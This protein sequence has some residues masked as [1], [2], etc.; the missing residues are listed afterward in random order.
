MSD[1]QVT[2]LPAFFAACP[3][4]LETL[5]GEE[6]TAL[7]AQVEKTTV[8]GVH[9][10]GELAV[11]Y[12]ACLWSRLANRIILCLI[13]EEGVESPEQL[14]DAAARVA[15]A[16]HLVPGRSLAVD[17]H[18][19]SAT[20][21]HTRFGAQTVK[22]GVVTAMAR[23]G[24]ERPTVEP[25]D[26]DL[27][28]YAHLHRGRLTLGIDFSGESLH[29]RGYR[30]ELGHAPLKE[31]LAAALLMRA[32]WPAR[33]KAGEALVDPLCGSG[34]L[35]IEAALMA[36][37]IAPNLNRA[38]FGLEAWA[39][40]DRELWRELRREAEARASLG[41]KRCKAR[42]FGSDQSPQ[43][44]AAA[45]ANAMRAGIPA[46][47]HFQ[48]ASV[49][50]LK[51][52]ESLSPEA[53]GLVITNPPYGER[54]GELP[55]LVT[56]YRQLGERLREAFPGWNLALFTGNPDLGHR[57]GMRAHKHYAFRNG[58]LEARLLLIAIPE[59]SGEAGSDARPE[60]PARSENAQM[61]ANRLLKNRKRLKKWLK[62]SGESCYRLYDADMPE[63]ALAIDVYGD[64]VHVQEYAPPKSVDAAQAQKRL[65]DA[66]GVIPE[67]LEVSPSR[68]V[69]KRRERQ[70]GRAQYQKQGSHGE[71]FE[72]RE[73][74]ARLWVNLRDYLDTGLFLDH[75]PVRRRLAE[76]AAGKRFLNLFCYTATATVQAALGTEKAGGASDTISVDLSNTYLSWA[77][78][79]FALNG[80]DPAHHRVV[81]DD[82]LRWLETAKAEFDLIF[83]DP[84]TFSNSKK[85]EATLDIQRDH[86]RLI[87][88]AMARLAEDGT[89]VFSNNQRRFALDADLAEQYRVEEISAKTFDPDFKRNPDLHHVFLIRH[90]G[91]PTA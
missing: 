29:R 58:P 77:R 42:L 12:R 89:L 74:R 72:V 28:L 80:L 2:N 57:L 23:A 73:G 44:I 15:W 7:G 60:A 54:I 50:E 31:N 45:K 59:A 38:R 37:D 27:R 83:M 22:D 78:D 76:M 33:A 16:E 3:R 75:R 63:F 66:L 82:C 8:A 64:W 67:V 11:A 43:A 62:Q 53:R 48:G 68:V 70:S 84:P 25:R 79:N 85:M 81:R 71:R 36:A 5:L 13:R 86:G 19:Q 88:L 41:R 32:D 46:L 65:F 87:R 90:R 52:P 18:G 61:F 40:H 9:F 4:G 20:I 69:I 14:A 30:R 39:G 1:M 47:I 56:L 34:T 21:R 24:R 17:F 26:P 6:L 49:A 10:R 55:E 35:V 91:E 51:R